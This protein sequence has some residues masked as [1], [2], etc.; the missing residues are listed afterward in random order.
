MLEVLLY[1]HVQAK[2]A[3]L[4]GNLVEADDPIPYG[5]GKEISAAVARVRVC[6]FDVIISSTQV[7]QV[8]EQLAVQ[9]ALKDIFSTGS[10]LYRVCAL[11]ATASMT[12]P[13]CDTAG[14][15]GGCAQHG[16]RVV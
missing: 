12:G 13:D 2:K 6:L 7:R 15:R 9:N 5:L 1:V 4:L 10:E 8:G 16:Q 14:V 11:L 3:F